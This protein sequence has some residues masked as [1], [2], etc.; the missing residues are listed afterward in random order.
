MIKNKTNTPKT[1]NIANKI[2]ELAKI[3]DNYKIYEKE[4]EDITKE[5]Q[6]LNKYLNTEYDRLQEIDWSRQIEKLIGNEY[7]STFY[8]EI[9]K[10]FN[11]LIDQNLP[12]KMKNSEN[13]MKMK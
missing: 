10:T 12:Q 3:R 6:K 5:I 4:F 7:S 13:R 9:R 1:L 11:G 2:I 8:K